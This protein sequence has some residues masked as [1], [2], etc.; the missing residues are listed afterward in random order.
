MQK[1]C[2]LLM[3]NIFWKLWGIFLPGGVCILRDSNS[4]CRGV[5]HIKQSLSLE[6]AVCMG[7]DSGPT[8]ES[9]VN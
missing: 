3:S 1:E 9:M 4:F 8:Q 7:V 2:N 5:T 6:I